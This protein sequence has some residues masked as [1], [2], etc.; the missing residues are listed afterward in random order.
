MTRTHDGDHGEARIERI[1][2]LALVRR[3][4]P[5]VPA[6]RRAEWIAEWEGELHHAWEQPG[7]RRGATARIGLIA[8]S[9]GSITDAL[10][11]RRHN[12][13]TD[14]LGTD[15]RYALRTM[16]RRPGFATVVILTLALGI[17]ATTAIFSVVNAVLLRPLPFPEAERLFVLRGESTS[18]DPE[19]VSAS[20]SY[21]DFTDYRSHGRS[22]SEMAAMRTQP[23]TLLDDA[24]EPVRVMSTFATGELWGM[25]RARTV[26]GR[27][28]LPADDLRGAP[29]VAVIA[30]QLWQSRYGGDGGVV[31]QTVSLGGEPVTIVGV[32][33]PDF[34]LSPSTMIW[35]PLVPDGMDASR[36]VHRLLV[37]GRLTAGVR[38]A[39]AE[40]E[41]ALVARRL[42][43]E[44]P[45]DNT[46]R[47][48]RLEPLHEAVVGD[49]RPA[50][51]MLLGAVCLVL[52]IGCANLASLF[53]ARAAAREREIAVRTALGA[54][55]GRL[56]RQFLTESFVLALAGGAAGLFVAWAGMRAL[57]AWVPTTL[58]RASEIAL[59]VPVLL[60]LLAV[61]CLVGLLFGVLPGLQLRRQDSHAGSLRDGVRGSTTGPRARRLR[62]GL[63]VGEVALATLLLVG[64]ALLMQSFWRLQS[65]D[66]GFSPD[67]LVVAPI[68]LPTASYDSGAEVIEFYDRLRTAISALPGVEAVAL[69]YEHPLSPGWTSSFA[70][71]GRDAPPQGQEPEAR[72]RPVWPG[73][74]ETVGVRLVQGRDIDERDR[75]HAPGAVVVN[76]AFVR[77]H[78][79]EGKV[80]GQRIRALA[81]SAGAPADFAIV[82]V[83]ADEPY[84]GRGQPADPAAYYSH[85]QI[86]L[87]DM[88]LIVRAAGDP[89]ALAPAI[90]ERIWKIDASLP[91]ERIV[92]MRTL[93]GESVAEPRFNATLLGLFAFA[94]LLLAAVGIYGVL[95]YT[96]A[97][98]TGEIGVRMA[99]G[100]EQWSVMRLV[101][102]EGLVVALVGVVIG[103]GSAWALTRVMSSLLHGVNGR[104]PAVFA[105]VAGLLAGV[106][107]LAAYVPAM[108][109]SRIDPVV[110]LRSD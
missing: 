81:W 110:A 74:F 19:K 101:V 61:S 84:N 62:H 99:L 82:G 1:P 29:P 52:L 75:M 103:L 72:V 67:G 66:P 10:W 33:A 45:A 37:L 5:L 50:L 3:I 35:R 79:P 91:V 11:L 38:P 86:P 70:I 95:S 96:V 6:S 28:L 49:T 7:N 12:G 36:G 9:L 58:P 30:H 68:Q 57:I 76:E 63:V 14:M 54:G 106:A 44:Y 24:N 65:A 32:L 53:L 60:F 42:E 51:L 16:R 23:A 80:L 97:Q 100:A 15:L 13:E 8:R 56:V 90:R 47:G 85:A 17:G 59:D 98:R 18:G 48:V 89:L 39:E 21:P 108:R 93:L 105:A 46:F 34:R 2:G 109:A 77:R 27:T 41:L 4:A 94:A 20:Q 102:G 73:Y 26:V 25:L 43:L 107:L 55:R 92:S 83:V 69:A 22:F 71:V 78:F 64:A 104:D 87:N 88:D 40:S 31:G